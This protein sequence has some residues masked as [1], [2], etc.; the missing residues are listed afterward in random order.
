MFSLSLGRVRSVSLFILAKGLDSRI[1]Y[2]HIIRST[3]YQVVQDGENSELQ[4][5]YSNAGNEK[6]H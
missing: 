5:G 1:P 4:V 6:S 3:S 2:Q